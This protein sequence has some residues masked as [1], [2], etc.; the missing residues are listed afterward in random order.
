MGL[1]IPGLKRCGLG[2]PQRRWWNGGRVE[3][4]KVSTLLCLIISFVKSMTIV[5]GRLNV[6]QVGW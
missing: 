5:S 2:N 1:Q 3:W 6:K 4:G